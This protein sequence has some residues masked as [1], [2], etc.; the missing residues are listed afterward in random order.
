M[1][2]LNFF[3][4]FLYYFACDDSGFSWFER[5]LSPF[6]YF[7]AKKI[8]QRPKSR[9]RASCVHNA[10]R[11]QILVPVFHCLC[12]VKNFK[13]SRGTSYKNPDSW[14]NFSTF[15]FVPNMRILRLFGRRGHCLLRGRE[16][17]SIF[18]CNSHNEVKIGLS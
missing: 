5:F 14:N 9:A 8:P 1:K 11:A 13:M 18:R 6:C 2:S 10:L 3:M 16:V 7:C 17:S 4:I 12:A 15:C